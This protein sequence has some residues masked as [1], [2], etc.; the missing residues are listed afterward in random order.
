MKQGL[1]GD[2][3]DREG[4]MGLIRGQRLFASIG[5]V[6]AGLVL[7]ASLTAPGA[8]A[9]ERVLDAQ[10]SLA[11]GCVASDP[12]D[13]VEDPGCPGGTHPPSGLFAAT[14]AVTTDFYGNMYISSFGKSTSGSQARID[15][16][17]P[18]GFFISEVKQVGAES[19]AVD[20][21]GN[22][23]VAAEIEAGVKPILRFEPSVY[24]PEEGEIEYGKAPVELPMPGT[25]KSA[26]FTGIAINPANDHLFANFASAGLAEFDSAEAGN[27][28]LSN[29]NVGTWPFGTGVAVD[30]SR[31]RLYA[32]SEDDHVILYKLNEVEGS[33]P[34]A[35][36]K[37]VGT[38]IDASDV[39]SKDFGL[40]LSLAVDEGTGDIYLLDGGLNVVYQF[41]E[42][43]TYLATI[44]N[45]FNVPFGAE[46][47]IDNG[48]FSPNGAPND[49]TGG[50]Y[51]YVPS[52]KTGA[53]HSFAFEETDFRPPEVKSIAASGVTE[54]EAE[55]QATLN[56]GNSRR[57]SLSNTRPN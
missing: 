23:Y 36:H 17:D 55:F 24:K 28:E 49:G 34:N 11:G 1:A 4:I 50:R 56:P 29:T 32:T 26:I 6:L 37:K 54:D 35:E 53:G 2:T 38:I 12:L 45:S 10:L 30:A 16:F 39:P 21:K 27:V 42:N 47:G 52:G 14:K 57:R 15:I 18:N 41:D 3:N 5:L 22:L 51:L 7:L 9:A 48:P 31:G 44:K 25:S 13:E 40:Y 19:V 8:S 46:I 20:S 43:G 33:P